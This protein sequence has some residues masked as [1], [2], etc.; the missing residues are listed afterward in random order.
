MT[1]SKNGN[2]STEQSSPPAAWNTQADEIELADCFGVLWKRRYFVSLATLIPTITAAAVLFFL[3][4]TYRSVFLYEQNLTEKNF[5]ILLNRFYSDD[6][7]S[8]LKNRLSKEELS[9]YGQLFNSGE[10]LK[11]IIVIEA[12]PPFVDFSKANITNPDQIN[13]LK[14]MKTSLL[15]VNV[16]GKSKDQVE[17][18]SSVVRNNIENTL[19]LYAIR[20][21]LTGIIQTDNS[22]LAEIENGRYNLE[23]NLKNTKLTL[24][25]LK[26]L[27][28]GTVGTVPDGIAIQFNIENQDKYLPLVSQIQA[29]ESTRIDLEGTVKTN[30]EN[31]NYYKDLL[32][33]D[34]RILSEIDSKLVSDYTLEQYNTYLIQLAESCKKAY[35]KDF[36]SSYARKIENLISSSK[37][38]MEKPTIR[39]VASGIVKKTGIVCI[40]SFLMSIIVVFFIKSS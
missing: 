37:P 7:L 19:S 6:N 29:A 15:K 1:H 20:D 38:V 9:A 4:K 5:T 8:N 14:D 34:N 3:P 2:L 39:P 28:S 22:K 10:Q 13:K 35:E 31:Y 16:F 11:K 21:Q 23:L 24:E 40:L 25:S 27:N 17:Q 26:S 36:L 32:E 33:L 12:V 30:D 18:L